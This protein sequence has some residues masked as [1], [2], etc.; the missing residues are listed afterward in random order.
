[1]YICK[2]YISH[3][4]FL[5]SEPKSRHLSAIFFYYLMGLSAICYYLLISGNTNSIACE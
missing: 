3:T 2:Y 1:M 4:F 5:R